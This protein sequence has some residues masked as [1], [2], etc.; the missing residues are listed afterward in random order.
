MS[1]K[2]LSNYNGRV[3]HVE[4]NDI[5][6]HGPGNLLG[7][8]WRQWRAERALARRGV[9]F[10][11]T[12][13]GALAA[14]Y[15][16]MNDGEFGAING[17]QDWANWRTIPRSLSGHVPDRPLRVLDLGCGSGGSTRVLAFYCP[18]GSR[19]TGYELA[20]PLVEIA[21]RR[22]YRHR[23]GRPA[24]VAFCCQ[25]VTDPLPD[26]DGSVD[27]VS[28]SGVV[29]HHL[30]ATTVRPLIG[31]LTRVLRPG[32]VALLDVGPTLGDA[33]LSAIMTAGGLARLG[34]RRS[35]FLDR[36]GQ[37][38]YRADRSGNPAGQRP[39]SGD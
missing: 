20:A 3:L 4:E 5:R 32:G 38:I 16:A 26:P 27:V 2:F 36:T 34:Y 9:H 19:I 25:G 39:Q 33:E 35:C 31:E 29:G 1:R 6:R 8:C 14:A 12:D 15:A 23:S 28:A 18:A 17:R 21:R 22:A 24:D 37:V 11:T 7:V 13:V 10:R 30:D